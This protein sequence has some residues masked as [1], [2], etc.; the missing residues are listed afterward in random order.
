[1]AHAHTSHVH[2]RRVYICTWEEI[3]MQRLKTDNPAFSP[4]VPVARLKAPEPTHAFSVRAV[5]CE[6]SIST[7]YFV[8]DK[9]VTSLELQMGRIPEQD[10]AE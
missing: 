8:S 7:G 5:S 9:E 4:H 3:R 2:S 6:S 1:M 10:K